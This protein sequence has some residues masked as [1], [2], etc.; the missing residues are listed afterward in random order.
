M[1]VSISNFEKK[2]LLG[3]KEEFDRN[4]SMSKMYRACRAFPGRASEPSN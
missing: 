3:V 1:R 2:N 4:D